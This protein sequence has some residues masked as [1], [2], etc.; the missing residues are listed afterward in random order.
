MEDQAQHF[1]DCRL[2]VRNPNRHSLSR[3]LGAPAEPGVGTRSREDAA[4]DR[5]ARGLWNLLFA[6]FLQLPVAGGAPER[7]DSDSVHRAPAPLLSAHP[8]A[9]RPGAA[10][11]NVTHYLSSCLQPRAGLHP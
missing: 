9:E 10:C 1:A 8:A 6:L 5:I 7:H 2:A 11:E 4:E 3:G